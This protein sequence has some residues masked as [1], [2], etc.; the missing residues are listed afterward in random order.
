MRGQRLGAFAALD[1]PRR[2][3]AVGGPDAA[4]FPAGV[5]IVD[6]AVESLRI[7]AERVGHAEHHH[8]AVRVRDQAV[9]QIAGGHGNVFAESERVMLI[10]PRVV[11]GLGA[12]FADAV[13]AGTG[14]LMERPPLGALIAGGLR[15][16]ERT[17]ALATIEAA[18][19]PA[20]ERHPDDAVAIDVR[21]ARAE[22]GRGHVVNLRQRR[23]RRMRSERDPHDGSGIAHYRAPDGSIRGA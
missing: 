20:R 23:L 9:V 1:Q 10:D 22:T 12:V 11:A 16:V 15:S 8:A 6:A 14:I 18:E 4:P 19:M 13:E 3:V 21:A 17:F 7:E 5:R 2:A